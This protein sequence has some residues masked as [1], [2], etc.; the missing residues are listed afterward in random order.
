MND[1]EAYLSGLKTKKL[2]R[3]WKLLERRTNTHHCQYDARHLRLV[4]SILESRASDLHSKL[5][6]LEDKK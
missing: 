5:S 3:I 1:L 4:D 6:Y 2:M